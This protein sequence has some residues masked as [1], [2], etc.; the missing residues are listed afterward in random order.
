MSNLIPRASA[1]IER[2]G[3]SSSSDKRIAYQP[4][5]NVGWFQVPG[6]TR[7]VVASHVGRMARRATSSMREQIAA[8][9]S[10]SEGMGLAVVH[11]HPD[12]VRQ[13][14]VGW[15]VGP[16]VL[17]QVEMERELEQRADGKFTPVGGW[18]VMRIDYHP[19]TATSIDHHTYAR[20]AGGAG[21]GSAPPPAT[22]TNDPLELLPG[23]VVAPLRPHLVATDCWTRGRRGGGR[24]VETVTAYALDGDRLVALRA[25]RTAGTDA[26]LPSAS[27]EVT[28]VA[29]TV[30][31]TEHP[32]LTSATKAALPPPKRS[33]GRALRAL[34][35]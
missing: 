25:T 19:L 29:A 27:W 2:S 32:A 13:H 17:V 28:T 11:R 1:G 26:D 33:L 4:A 24:V 9:T 20:R 34:G 30:G 7:S 8:T 18:E 3:K 31:E 16:L 10:L 14:Q 23:V 21:G 6:H 22:T 5:E 35:R 15:W 12:G